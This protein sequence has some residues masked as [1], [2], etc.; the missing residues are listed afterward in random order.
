LQIC[1][2]LPEKNLTDTHFSDSQISRKMIHGGDG[3]VGIPDF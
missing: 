1:R 2:Y 3:A